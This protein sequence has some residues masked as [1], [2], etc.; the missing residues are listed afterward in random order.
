MRATF[1]VSIM[2][3]CVNKQPAQVVTTAKVSKPLPAVS[4]IDLISASKEEAKDLAKQQSDLRTVRT[5]MKGTEGNEEQ[6]DVLGFGNHL[7]IEGA[8][9]TSH[10]GGF[11]DKA[12]RIQIQGLSLDQ[13]AKK[14][15]AYVC[16]KGLKPESPNQDDFCLTLDGDTI[17]L[18]VFDGHGP[19]GHE[20]SHFVHRDLMQQIR[21]STEYEQRPIEALKKSFGATNEN[22]KA[23]CGLESTSCDCTVSGTTA[24]VALF[25]GNKLLLGHVGDSRVIMAIRQEGVLRAQALTSD[26]KPLHPEEKQRIEQSGGE[27]KQLPGDIPYRVFAKGTEDPGLSMSRSI[28]DT[29][30][31]AVGVICEPD[32]VELEVSE[33]A[34]FVLLCSDGI[35]EFVTNE[36]AVEVVGK[37]PRQQARQAAE[38]LAQLA[39]MRWVQNEED[40]VDDI[41]VLLA[42][43]PRP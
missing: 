28:G 42:Y 23:Y 17:L 5:T 38:K 20:I 32:V 11:E 41:T 29:D 16:K 6:E 15:L 39:W 25:R 4:T 13:L 33:N 21:S 37:F 12:T 8:P 27:V 35:W 10:Q 34:E 31:Q 43:V 36:E 24:S 18:G 1:T 40:T 9:T 14:G 22:L 19:Y 2:G 3:I 26:H 7:H 30:A